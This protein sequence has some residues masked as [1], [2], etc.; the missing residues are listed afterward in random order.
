MNKEGAI[1]GR[2]PSISI[3]YSEPN[4][5]CYTFGDGTCIA[6]ATPPPLALWDQATHLLEDGAI[7][8]PYRT[9][10]A[11]LMLGH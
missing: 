2:S 6:F 9:M 1:I 8:T 7:I 10:G 3:A 5:Y 4:I 11:T